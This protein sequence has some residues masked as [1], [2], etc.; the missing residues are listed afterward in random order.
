MVVNRKAAADEVREQKKATTNIGRYR[1]KNEPPNSKSS[2]QR[3]GVVRATGEAVE[4]LLF[5]NN[6]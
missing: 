3:P 1:W 4:N 6:K 2:R 5:V